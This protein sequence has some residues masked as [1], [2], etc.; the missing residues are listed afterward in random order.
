MCYA[1]TVTNDDGTATAFCCCGWSADH[2]TP[3]AADA[4]A[5]RHQTAAD[6]TESPL[7]A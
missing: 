6:A 4:D 7:A 5:E 1:D 3:D 2:A